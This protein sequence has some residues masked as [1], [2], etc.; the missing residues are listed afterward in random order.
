[1][2]TDKIHTW[3]EFKTEAARSREATLPISPVL[4][5][6]QADAAWDLDTTLE[7]SGHDETVADF[8]RLILRV[9]TE[10]EIATHIKWDGYPTVPEMENLSRDYDGFS[11]ALANLP[12]YAY[13]AY[14]RHHGFP[15]PL[16]DWSRSPFVA[17][18]FAFR[19]ISILNGTLR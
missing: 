10:V 17:A 18:Y 4:F 2:S 6:G 7:R 11:R 12:H 3:E 16:L 19:G 13:M 1:M 15:S 9:K 14:L 5:R 8:Y